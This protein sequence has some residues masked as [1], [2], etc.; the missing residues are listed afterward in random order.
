MAGPDDNNIVQFWINEHGVGVALRG[1]VGER[2]QA[3]D[4]R[5]AVPTRDGKG[6]GGVADD[7]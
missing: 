1:G 4:K 5:R 3:R 7:V 2:I 6:Q